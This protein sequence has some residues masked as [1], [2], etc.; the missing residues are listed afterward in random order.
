MPYINLETIKFKLFIKKNLK[1]SYMIYLEQYLY[2]I[3]LFKDIIVF[4]LFIFLDFIMEK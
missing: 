3:I 2:L 4:D 1:Q